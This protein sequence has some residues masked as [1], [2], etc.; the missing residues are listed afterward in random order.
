MAALSNTNESCPTRDELAGFLVGEIDSAAD[1]RR[2]DEH[3]A[4]CDA[5][6]DRLQAISDEGDPLLRALRRPSSLA[7][8]EAEGGCEVAL[9]RVRRIAL[10]GDEPKT[11]ESAPT[12]VEPNSLGDTIRDEPAALRPR[13][14]GVY[15]L[16]EPIRSGGMGTLY[17]ARHMRLK[18]F[19]ALKMLTPARWD[20]DDSRQRFHREMEAIG[21]ITHP[22]IVTAFDAGEEAGHP[23]LVMELLEGEDL[24]ALARRWGKLPVADACEMVRQAALGLHCAHQQGVIHRDIKP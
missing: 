18:R 19:V 15:E 13:R 5:C 24:A 11:G 20:R 22:N 3:L 23:F 2:I 8:Y 17:R 10:R 1:L 14:L 6:L 7:T 12:S 9:Q 16:L 4:E 21:R